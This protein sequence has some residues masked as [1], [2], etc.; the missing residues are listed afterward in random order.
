MASQ[1]KNPAAVA[2]GRRGAKARMKKLTPE[3]RSEV[4][5]RAV[6]ARWAKE[7]GKE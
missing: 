1:K 4:A 5:R 7:K 2:L 3:Q 6:Q